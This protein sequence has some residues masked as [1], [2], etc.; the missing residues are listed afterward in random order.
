M[1]TRGVNLDLTNTIVKALACGANAVMLGNI[2][3]RTSDAPGKE[4]LVL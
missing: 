4:N 1:L 3:A 2:F